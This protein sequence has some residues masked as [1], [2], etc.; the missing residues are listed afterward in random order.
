MAALAAAALTPALVGLTEGSASVVATNVAYP[1][2]DLILFLFVVGA[3]FVMGGRGGREWTLV[4]A[5]L[6]TLGIADSIYL[7]QVAVDSYSP[8]TLLD[9][10]WLANA[11][12]LSVAAWTA[13]TRVA[14]RER[15][16]Q[17]LTL[18]IAFAAV[19]VGILVYQLFEPV[20]RLA[21]GLAVV[22]LGVAVAR[23][24][25][26]LAE[27]SRLL[28]VVQAEA[29]TDALTEL[30]NR[31]A[32]IADLERSLEGI[33]E[34]GRQFVFALYDLD[35]FKTYNDRFGHAAGDVLL[36]RLG[37]SLA[38]TLGARGHAY[39]LGGDEFCVL[40]P[41]PRDDALLDRAATA[42]SESGHGF[43][44]G[45][46]F[47]LAEL[48]AEARD[49]STAL[50]LADTRMYAA[51]RGR[52]VSAERQ[53]RDVL[54]TAHGERAPQIGEH[55]RGVAEDAVQMG[56]QLGLDGE[57]IDILRRAAE[58]HDIGKIAIPEAIVEKPGPLD[59]EELRLMKRHTL[60]GE[61]IL[62][63]AP[64]MQPVA[65]VVRSTHERWDGGGYPDGL[66]GE[67]IPLAS[68]I[69]SVCDA[70]DAMTNDRPYRRAVALE[71][72]LA[73]IHRNAGTQFDPDL[74]ER[75]CAMVESKQSLA[76]A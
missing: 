30:R 51:K 7:Y 68:R 2:A 45:N 41:G 74:A 56:Q 42:L 18:V 33:A 34:N 62:A 15:H 67:Q 27:N 4:T 70:F 19:A 72:A 37:R 5:G 48:P 26:V 32:L 71:Q 16:I 65:K 29:I 63:A 75:F 50:K 64:A 69:I 9:A 55:S 3:W 38:A 35:G 13:P 14:R 73:E 40:I 12:L 10:L 22:A 60:I 21:E 11:A 54:L 28:E 43:Q 17:P 47:G 6:I 23:L 44:I 31:R 1:L 52:R 20:S 59:P 39:R 25:L 24:L 76:L 57:Q 53:T 49:V 8:G 66:A 46:S 58:L 36:R 61:R